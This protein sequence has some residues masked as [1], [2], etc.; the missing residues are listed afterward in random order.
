MWLLFIVRLRF[1][2]DTYKIR[3][4]LAYLVHWVSSVW[5][6]TQSL[7]STCLSERDCITI[8]LAH[9]C[10]VFRKMWQHQG[11]TF[12]VEINEI[13][14]KIAVITVPQLRTL[15]ESFRKNDN[16]NMCLI[17]SPKN[18]CH[19]TFGS[20]S[21]WMSNGYIQ[22]LQ[23]ASCYGKIGD[24][25]SITICHFKITEHMDIKLFNRLHI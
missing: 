23:F 10:H 2:K 21:F 16:H 3:Y 5:I 25:L 17:C 12:F 8:T 11:K 6:T 9:M 24:H 1:V 4:F 14:D 13:P 18:M 22:I 7:T 19:M 20:S 15:F